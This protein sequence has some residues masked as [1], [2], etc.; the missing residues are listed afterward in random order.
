MSEASLNR[1]DF[2]RMAVAAS[3]HE[4][5]NQIKMISQINWLRRNAALQTFVTSV[6]G[7]R[8]V[9]QRVS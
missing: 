5:E 7:R 6:V 1:I 3:Q 8:D 9:I 2:T 4:V